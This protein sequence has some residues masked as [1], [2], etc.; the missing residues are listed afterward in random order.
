MALICIG[1]AD[2]A[3]PARLG[4]G[5]QQSMEDVVLGAVDDS[6]VA[7][8]LDHEDV[9]GFGSYQ[10][11]CFQQPDSSEG[12]VRIILSNNSRTNNISICFFG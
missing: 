3:G 10:P 5:K 7:N 2:G 6:Q 11:S 12:E 4:P 1:T 9:S 8:D